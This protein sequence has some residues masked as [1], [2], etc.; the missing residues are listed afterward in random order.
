MNGLNRFIL[1]VTGIVGLVSVGVLLLGVYE[2]PRLSPSLERWQNQDEYVYTV[3]AISIFLG[4]V[5]ILMLLTG[6]I[7]TSKSGRYTIQT[8][9]GRITISTETIE[10][11]VYESLKMF[12]GVRTPDVKVDIDSK[13]ESVHVQIDCSVFNREGLPTLGKEIQTHVK[14]RLEALLELPVTDVSLNIQDR[15]RHTS[16][17][18]V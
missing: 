10:K 6:L 3:L 18:V 9:E 1:V 4:I 16:E 5:F 17:R 13:K 11:M 7:A 8:G 12:E 15:K 2:V 14:D